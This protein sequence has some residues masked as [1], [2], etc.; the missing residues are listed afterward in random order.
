MKKNL[1]SVTIFILSGIILAL[2]ISQ[3]ILYIP[4]Q[5]EM[6]DNA[7]TQGATAEQT[8]D[9]YWHEFIPQ[10]LTYAITFLG[11]ATVLFIAGMLHLRLAA[12]QPS[13]HR[14]MARPYQSNALADDE[15]DDFF[16][17]FEVIDAEP[18]K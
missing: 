5:L 4:P 1:T 9:Y 16:E 8:S 13:N 2:G 10:V 11:F 6:L 15:L 7:V 3:L 18:E 12:Y 14:N 17:E